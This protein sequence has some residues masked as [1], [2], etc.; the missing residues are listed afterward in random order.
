M[1]NLFLFLCLACC[2]TACSSNDESIPDSNDIVIGSWQLESQIVDGSETINAC[3]SQTVFTFEPDLILRQVFYT[4]NNGICNS[5]NEIISSWFN[6]GNSRYSIRS[7]DG[8]S[9]VITLTFSSSNTE[10]SLT[11][12]V[13]GSTIYSLFKKID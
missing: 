6:N 9:K 5:E 1:K 13:N 10:Y 7:A 2:I 12:T 4:E 3:N 11:E 8:S